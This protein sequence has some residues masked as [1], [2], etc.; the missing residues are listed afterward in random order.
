MIQARTRQD[1]KQIIEVALRKEFPRD[2]VDVS[3]GY[4]DN[5]HVIVVSRKFDGMT[6]RDKTDL[7]WKVIDGTE[8]SDAEKLKISLIMPVSPAEI[9]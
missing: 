3:D 5:I 4:Q 1:I 7:L 8:L 6:E 2:T 9:K